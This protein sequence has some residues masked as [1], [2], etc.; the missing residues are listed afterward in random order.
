METVIKI[1]KLLKQIQRPYGRAGYLRHRLATCLIK[2][3]FIL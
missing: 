3:D 2:E 1:S